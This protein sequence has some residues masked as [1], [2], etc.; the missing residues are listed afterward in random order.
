MMMVTSLAANPQ[1]TRLVVYCSEF[2][3]DAYDEHSFIFTIYTAD[4]HY[5][6]QVTQIKYGGAGSG[7]NIAE[8]SGMFFDQYGMVYIA[9]QY[10]GTDFTN[11]EDDSISDYAPRFGI[12]GY[13]PDIEDLAF[14]HHSTNFGESHTVT[15][16][17][18]G[19]TGSNAYF[20]GAVNTCYVSSGDSSCWRLAINRVKPTG[21]NEKQTQLRYVDPDHTDQTNYA[22]ID[23]MHNYNDGTRHWFFGSTQS[24]K[25]DQTGSMMYMWRLDLDVDD[26]PRGDVLEMYKMASADW[27]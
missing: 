1:G 9:V 12:V 4:G 27:S 22:T 10:F 13:Q 20:G 3:I 5:A 25:L 17:D 23:Q 26:N 11:S 21:Y 14:F 24:N 6:T 8:S 19:Q 7:E 18:H 16:I 2:K 15:Y